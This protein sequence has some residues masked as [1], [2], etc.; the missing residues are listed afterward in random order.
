MFLYDYKNSNLSYGVT[1]QECWMVY[2]L[3]ATYYNQINFIPGVSFFLKKLNIVISTG[4][5]RTLII[6]CRRKHVTG[7]LAHLL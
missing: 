6:L 4:A 3:M 2:N 7:F 1:K 5:G